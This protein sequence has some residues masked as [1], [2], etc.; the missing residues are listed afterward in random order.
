[1]Q[2]ACRQRGK[3]GV[4]RQRTCLR[5]PESEP[6]TRCER[7]REAGEVLRALGMELVE[8]CLEREP[9]VQPIESDLESDPWNQHRVTKL[10]VDSEDTGAH[11][12]HA[13]VRGEHDTDKPAA[14]AVAVLE[15]TAELGE[16]TA[17][18]R[19]ERE[20]GMKRQLVGLVVL[21]RK[22]D[23]ARGDLVRDRGQLRVVAEHCADLGLD[24]ETF[25][26]L[27][28]ARGGDRAT[29]EESRP[30]ELHM[31]S[32]HDFDARDGRRFAGGLTVNRMRGWLVLVMLATG[33]NRVLGLDETYS[34]DARPDAVGCS[35]AV[36]AGPDPLV[37]FD[38]GDVEFDSQLRYDGLELFFS[39]IANG[40]NETYVATRTS[41]VARFGPPMKASFDGPISDYDSA[42]SGD[43]LRLM[44][45][46]DRN[47]TNEVFEVTRAAI[48]Q[49]FGAPGAVPVPAINGLI[50]SID[51]SDDG[52]HLYYANSTGDLWMAKRSE[53]GE[54]FVDAIQLLENAAVFPTLSPDERELFYA[55]SIDIA[56]ASRL[57]DNGGDPDMAADGTTMTLSISSGLSVMTRPC[58]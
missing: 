44:F 39:K 57:R 33:C 30:E 6:P 14:E 12:L 11:P 15:A 49:P 45:V 5:I 51:L 53:L 18:V 24:V 52:R 23:A 19:A 8:R 36:F 29:H 47:S 4:W 21:L 48:D 37:E 17:V 13:V 34:I 16:P 38:D 1:V 7:N 25:G 9:H 50:D 22:T 2:A 31:P 54:P 55:P 41:T 26:E 3:L 35:G 27:V 58:M 20:Q 28:G 43:G 40:R 56:T 42:L 32:S 46:S 10:P